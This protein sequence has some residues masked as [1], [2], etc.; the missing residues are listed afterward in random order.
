MIPNPKVC[1]MS[2]ELEI[3]RETGLQK[4]QLDLRGFWRAD[5]ISVKHDLVCL[6]CPAEKNHFMKRSRPTSTDNPEKSHACTPLTISN[7]C[8]DV[9]LVV[10][11]S[12]TSA[13]HGQALCR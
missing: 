9:R 12:E 2:V 11:T 1:E 4:S 8:F 13:W 3:V 6:L 7:G 5:C 10:F